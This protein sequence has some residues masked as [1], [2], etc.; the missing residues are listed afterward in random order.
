MMSDWKTINREALRIEGNLKAKVQSYWDLS[1]RLEAT[2]GATR[3]G[4]TSAYD[5]ENPA[6]NMAEAGL[7]REVDH[8]LSQLT[9]M[10]DA[11]AA[12]P[13]LRTIPQQEQMKRY[14]VN[15][16][17]SRAEYNRASSAIQRHRDANELFR[18]RQARR[19][20]AEGADADTDHLLRESQYIGSSLRGASNVLGQAHEARESL[21][22]QR[23]TLSRTNATLGALTSAFPGIG[24]IVDQIGRRRTRDN[25]I[26][27]TV[28]ALCI[29]F[30][31]WWLL[32]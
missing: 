4:G 26:V 16:I 25:M 29:C 14:R 1:K 7:A 17:D 10:L 31:L 18:G 21:R 12:A 22:Q 30:T 32:S 8:L 28:L 24:R 15:L 6:D 27:A 11:M 19:H 9:E 3:N 23:E 5:L 2:D 20:K 13:G